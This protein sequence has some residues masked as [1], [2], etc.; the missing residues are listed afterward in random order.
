MSPPVIEVWD[1]Y[2]PW[3]GHE[4]LRAHKRVGAQFYKAALVEV[5]A[6][7]ASANC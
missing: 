4:E 6:N 3:S 2:F 7:K 5:D 1:C